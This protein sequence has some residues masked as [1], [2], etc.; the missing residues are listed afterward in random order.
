MTVQKDNIYEFGF[1]RSDQVSK[2]VNLLDEAVFSFLYGGLFKVLKSL[3]LT[4]L[5]DLEIVFRLYVNFYKGLSFYD[6]QY[7][8][9]SPERTLWR[10]LKY[11]EENG[12]IRKSKNQKDKRTIRFLSVSY[13]HLTLPTIA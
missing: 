6:I 10:R 12:V 9:Q 13:T 8:T 3:A 2:N 5:L 4:S 1:G 7:F 11:L